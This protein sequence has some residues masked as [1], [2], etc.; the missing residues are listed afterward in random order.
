MKGGQGAAQ[1][2][3]MSNQPFPRPPYLPATIPTHPA[4]CNVSPQLFHYAPQ[5]RP[6]NADRAEQAP[7]FVVIKGTSASHGRE[8][9]AALSAPI[10]PSARLT[11]DLVGAK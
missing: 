2:G 11:L 7:F 4:G 8:V 1:L 10:Y 9:S 6:Y 3:S 5:P